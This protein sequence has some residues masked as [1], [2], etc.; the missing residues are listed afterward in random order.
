MKNEIIKAIVLIAE[1]L[2]QAEDEKRNAA[3]AEKDRAESVEVGYPIG[4]KLFEFD[5]E[6]GLIEVVVFSTR[7]VA[8]ENGHCRRYCK[9]Y[10]TFALT[11]DEAIK[12]AIEQAKVAGDLAPCREA[13]EWNLKYHQEGL[14]LNT[15]VMH[16]L[17]DSCT[18]M[19]KS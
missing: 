8:N 17:E 14:Q 16:M 5:F 11:E 9:K 7:E 3:R 12:A 19:K 15:A 13:L 10:D 4:T 18:L 2:V 6:D 1:A